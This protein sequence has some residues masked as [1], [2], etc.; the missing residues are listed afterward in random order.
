MIM[1][2][3]LRVVSIT[4]GIFSLNHGVDVRCSHDWNSYM[5]YIRKIVNL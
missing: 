3:R 5:G 4:S 2:N 1:T